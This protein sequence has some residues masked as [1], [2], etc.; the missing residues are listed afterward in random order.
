MGLFLQHPL[1]GKGEDKAEIQTI[2]TLSSVRAGLL[3]RVP[4]LLIFMIREM[5]Y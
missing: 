2:N 1:V 5:K 3:Q 4:Y